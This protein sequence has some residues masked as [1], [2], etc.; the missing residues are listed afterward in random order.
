MWQALL[1]PNFGG[2]AWLAQHFGGLKFL[3]QNW[4]GGSSTALGTIVFLV[5]WQFVPFHTF[6]YQM[7]RR[8]IPDVLYQ[9]A[10]VDGVTPWQQFRYVT[11]P[12]LCYTNVVSSTLIVVGSLTYFDIIYIL[13]NGGPGDTTRVLSLDMHN[14]AFFNMTFGYASVLAVVLGEMIHQRR[15]KLALSASELAARVGIN[16]STIIRLEHGGI[17]APRADKLAR[18]AEVLGLTLADVAAAAGYL[19]SSDLPSFEPYLIAK[20]PELSEAAMTELT[21]RFKELRAISRDAA[22]W[23]SGG[24]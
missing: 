21:R 3:Q 6:L 5:A 17:R 23:E 19:V 20:Y 16:S 7:G 2:L 1:D 18:L 4:L 14:A 22:N 11:L 10:I 8:Q 24:D 9:A 15:T 12:Q 13:T